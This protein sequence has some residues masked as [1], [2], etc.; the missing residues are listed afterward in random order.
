MGAV[1]R[2]PAA[3]NE[4]GRKRTS[5]GIRPQTQSVGTVSRV[6]ATPPQT[7]RVGAG[8]KLKAGAS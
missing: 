8:R 1:I 7:Q 6:V 2:V 4:P 3:G 5:A